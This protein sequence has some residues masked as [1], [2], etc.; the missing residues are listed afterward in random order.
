MTTTIL[1]VIAVVSVVGILTFVIFK[2]IHGARSVFKAQQQAKELLDKASLSQEDRT[3]LR[4]LKEK[5][6]VLE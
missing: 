6:N 4:E 5:D 3:I 1:I 2:R